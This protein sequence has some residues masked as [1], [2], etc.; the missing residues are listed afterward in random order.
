MFFSIHTHVVYRLSVDNGYFMY[1]Y[2]HVHIYV[3]VHIYDVALTQKGVE[4]PAKL[5]GE[6]SECQIRQE[7]N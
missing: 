5:K 6:N 1:V 2:I 3:L 7:A 4:Q